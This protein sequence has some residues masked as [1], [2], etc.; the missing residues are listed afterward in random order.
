MRSENARLG[1]RSW[2]KAPCSLLLLGRVPGYCS[3]DEVC[4][5]TPIPSHPA[6]LAFIDPTG[7]ELCAIA[8]SSQ[9]LSQFLTSVVTLH[10][11]EGNLMPTW[12]SP[13]KSVSFPSWP[14][15]V[16]SCLTKPQWAGV[17]TSQLFRGGFVHLKQILDHDFASSFSYT[18]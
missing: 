5:A 7:S 10:P 3:R 8:D 12:P 15:P 1:K 14:F 17:L 9:L 18:I 6:P 13:V 2:G 16:L 11:I 4:E